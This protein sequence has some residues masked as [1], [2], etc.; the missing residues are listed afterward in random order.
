[1]KITSMTVENFLSFGK[2]RFDFEDQGLVLVEGDNQDDESARSNGSGKSAMIDALVWCLFGTTL[3]GYENDEVVHRKV[4]EDCVVT[5]RLVPNDTSAAYDVMRFRKHKKSKNALIVSEI[6]QGGDSTDLSRPST[7]ETQEVV[8]EL[9]GCSRRTFLSSVVFGQDR[10]YRF[11]SLT[12]KEQKEIL[13]EVLG[14]ERF[15][16]ACNVARAKAAVIGTTV[17]ITKRDLERVEEARDAEDADAVDLRKKDKQYESEHETKLGAEKEKLRKAKEWVKKNTKVD[18]TKLKVMFDKAVQ[19]VTANEKAVGVCNKAVTEAK[20]LRGG[21]KTKVDELRAHVKRHEALTGDCPTCGQNVDDLQ[22]ERVVGDFKK[23]LTLAA[24][25]LEKVDVAVA[26]IEEQL[27]GAERKLKDAR[28]TA[29]A[30]QK[31]VNEGVGAEA[32]VASWRRRA[33]D[34][35]TRIK[36]LEAETNP[37]AALAKKAQAK[38]EKHKKGAELLTEQFTAEEARL[39]LVEF[40]VK[41]FGAR[42]LR[43]LLLDSSLPLLN[44]EADRVSRALTGG[45]I[46][47]EFSATSDLKSGKTIDRFEVKVDNKHGAGSY[48]GNSAGEKAKVDLCVGLALQKLVASRSSASFNLC[49]LD[50]VF[51]HLDSAAH[52]RVIEVLSEID[53]DSVFVVSHN[54]DLKAWFPATLRIVKKDGFSS[55]EAT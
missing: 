32:D 37:Y 10:A 29:V 5:V 24:K 55:V 48:Q 49:F 26:E 25:A 53:K 19:D 6:D 28:S 33:A 41:A 45:T 50:E 12:D 4:G 17:D 2:A 23:K 40:W 42:G 38:Y 20:V 51:D 3:R 36:E 7:S 44:Q 27:A 30:A 46:A 9:L 22:R 11:S 14:V 31:A 1:M 21:A 18:T 39:A 52:E 43:S 13:D 15:A 35:E 47:V 8:D 16:V 34:H 54:E